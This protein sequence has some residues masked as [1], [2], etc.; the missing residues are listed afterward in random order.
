[1]QRDFLRGRMFV[2]SAYVAVIADSA[3]VLHKASN[4]I[5]FISQ[6]FLHRERSELM[7]EHTM[8]RKRS[9]LNRAF[10]AA[11]ATG[12]MAMAALGASVA[13]DPAT[14]NAACAQGFTAFG[15]TGAASPS[16]INVG[17][18]N[19]VNVQTSFAGVNV[20]KNDASVGNNGDNKA[21]LS[22][23]VCLPIG[24]PFNPF[25]GSALGGNTGAA[26]PS[27]INVLSG[28]NINAQLSGF[29]PNVAFN[30]TNVGNNGGNTAVGS[31][32]VG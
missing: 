3:S 11:V 18:G 28:N 23:T 26:S 13:L 10:V 7:A 17:S 22:P 31:P 2:T 27:S 6:V 19:N 25:A 29:G 30:R 16:S 14:A 12:S 4:A 24:N 5:L 9:T 1:M 32:T 20:A 15:N 8:P 21:I